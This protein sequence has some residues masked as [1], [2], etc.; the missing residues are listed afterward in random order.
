MKKLAYLVFSLVLVLLLAACNNNN[1]NEGAVATTATP[2]TLTEDILPE[3]ILPETIL[4]EN[5]LA[6]NAAVQENEFGMNSFYEVYYYKDIQDSYEVGEY[7]LAPLRVWKNKIVNGSTI[8]ASVATDWTLGIVVKSYE[9]PHTY[10]YKLRIID[11]WTEENKTYIQVVMYTKR[12]ASRELVDMSINQ[13]AVLKNGEAKIFR[14]E[15]EKFKMRQV[16][17]PI[18]N[19]VVYDEC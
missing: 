7:Y 5:K 9:N 15:T 12:N 10:G 13:S 2:E 17:K 1:N 18:N 11:M 19:S 14:F 4:T 3:D 16:S 6:A 8:T